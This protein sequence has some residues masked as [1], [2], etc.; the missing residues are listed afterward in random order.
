MAG[1]KGRS[2]RAPNPGHFKSVDPR[3]NPGGQ[4]KSVKEVRRIALQQS[5]TAMAV[6]VSIACDKEAKDR[7]RIAAAREILDRGIGR[8]TVPVGMDPEMPLELSADRELLELFRRL[9]G[10]AGDDK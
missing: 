2:G 3:R 1:K 4:H 6:L 7:D 10:E 9:A 5:P 8:P